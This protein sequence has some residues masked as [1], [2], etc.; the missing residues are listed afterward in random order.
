MKNDKILIQKW[1]INEVDLETASN[2]HSKVKEILPQNII[3]ILVPDTWE[4]KVLEENVLYV[5]L[6]KEVD[7]H[8]SEEFFRMMKEEIGEG[9]TVVTNL[10]EVEI[11]NMKRV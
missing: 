10:C 5:K 11:I 3:P 8:L 7:F 1:N 2:F 6:D 4:F 9:Y